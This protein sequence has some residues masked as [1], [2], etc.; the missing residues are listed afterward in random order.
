MKLFSPKSAKSLPEKQKNFRIN[1]VRWGLLCLLIGV[2]ILAAKGGLFCQA[3]PRTP[4]IAAS[5][6][7]LT[8]AEQNGFKAPSGYWGTVHFL[9]RLESSSP[10]AQLFYYGKSELGRDLPALFLSRD[11]KAPWDPQKTTVLITAQVHGNEP[12][13]KE[14]ALILARELA[15]GELQSRL[16][17]LNLIV[18]P[19][20]N[21]D[22]AEFNRRLVTLNLDP[23]RDYFKLETP[24][25]RALV[26]KII[27]PYHPELT[28]DLHETAWRPDYDFMFENSVSSGWNRELRQWGE[29]K[30]LSPLRS[31]LEGEGWRLHRYLPADKDDEP[32]S[33]GWNFQSA[34]NYN[35]LSARVSLLLETVLPQNP[36]LGLKA[37]TLL[38]L[39]AVNFLLDR[40]YRLSGELKSAA[41]RTGQAACR[42][43]SSSPFTIEEAGLQFEPPR[44]Y[45]LPPHL[46][47]IAELL[48]IHGVR[49]QKTDREREF[50]VE[51]DLVSEVEV[52]EKLNQGH[53]TLRLETRRLT[54][55]LLFPAGSW[56]I[57]LNQPLAAVIVLM[58][59]PQSPDS[60][61][62]Y[63][64]L[65]AFLKKGKLLPVYRLNRAGDLKD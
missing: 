53:F 60:L 19:L 7:P 49:R 52:S 1:F 56:I 42:N 15:C 13:G 21:P 50:E 6:L 43:V 4:E 44:A 2:F 29:D 34:R 12:A 17:R 37:R 46:S 8:E 65:D 55:K 62:R 20:L 47:K 31:R 35:G 28:L 30:L 39:E 26:E 16:D 64:F 14:A 61:V 33:A 40:A 63:G 32:A 25:I 5:G 45:L 36:Q 57:P 58:L 3:D 10:R 41:E 9:E 23:N 59:E 22:G 51:A 48:K 38:H 11:R 24:E 18:C 54:K 27:A